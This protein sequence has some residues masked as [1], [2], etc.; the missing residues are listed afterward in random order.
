MMHDDVGNRDNYLP[1]REEVVEDQDDH[2]SS[3]DEA[4][5][6]ENETATEDG[7]QYPP[8]ESIEETKVA[9]ADIASQPD[10]A[11]A[12]L[13]KVSEPAADPTQPENNSPF[14]AS[15]SLPSEPFSVP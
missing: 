6:S 12:A 8:P 13:E 15:A 5:S 7:T 10:E 11:F 4:G 1:G 3:R 9:S 2:L 14:A